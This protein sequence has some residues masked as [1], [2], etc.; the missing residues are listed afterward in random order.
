MNGQEGKVVQRAST[1][2]L[3]LGRAENHRQQS[4][5]STFCFLI[6]ADPLREVI[7]TRQRF[8]NCSPTPLQNACDLTQ[9]PGSHS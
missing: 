1:Q 7:H 4:E 8:L 5:L 3:R 9:S 6:F 2:H